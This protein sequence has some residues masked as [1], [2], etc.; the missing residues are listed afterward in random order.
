MTAFENGV[1]YES[2]KKHN[3]ITTYI[4]VQKVASKIVSW[5]YTRQP[6]IKQRSYKM[7]TSKGEYFVSKQGELIQSWNTIEKT[8]VDSDVKKKQYTWDTLVV[9]M[10]PYGQFHIQKICKDD[11][12]SFLRFHTAP[13]KCFIME[14]SRIRKNS[15]RFCLNY[16]E[17]LNEFERVQEIQRQVMKDNL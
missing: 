1:Y 15:T 17:C 8:V 16:A 6:H 12:F 13:F 3:E 11:E 9:E 4:K 10:L 5:I 2:T 7:N 14:G